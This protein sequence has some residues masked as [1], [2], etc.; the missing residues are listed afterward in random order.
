MHCVIVLRDLWKGTTG[1]G[2]TMDLE[3]FVITKNGAH[4]KA[5]DDRCESV[6]ETY[7]KGGA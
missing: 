2:I 3:Q 1:S 5:D 6:F 4:Q 7:L